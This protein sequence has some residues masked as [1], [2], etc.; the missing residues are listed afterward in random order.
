MRSDKNLKVAIFL[1]FTILS[2]F[3][4]GVQGLANLLLLLSL[5]YRSFH[6]LA[7]CLLHLRK[8]FFCFF[9]SATCCFPSYPLLIACRK[10]LQ[11]IGS[12]LLIFPHVV[13]YHQGLVI[14]FQW[15]P[16]AWLSRGYQRLSPITLYPKKI[17]NY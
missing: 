12:S 13:F 9:L 10:T 7:C 14:T 17:H 1:S 5:P 2:T 8:F 15:Q 16:I 4:D 3:L 6:D 11:S